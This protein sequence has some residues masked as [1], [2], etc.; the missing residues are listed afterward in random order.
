MGVMGVMGVMVMVM[1]DGAAKAPASTLFVAPTR[2]AVQ[3]VLHQSDAFK[4]VAFNR[5]D[6]K[7][8]C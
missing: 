4:L 5:R 8:A 2:V 6:D 1:T 3:T 7:H